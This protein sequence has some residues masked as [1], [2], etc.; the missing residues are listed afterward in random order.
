MYLHVMHCVVK[1]T[2][3]WCVA[4]LVYGLSQKHL[5]YF[6][7]YRMKFTR[8]CVALLLQEVGRRSLRNECLRFIAARKYSSS[9]SSLLA[10]EED[11]EAAKLRVNLTCDQY[12]LSA[13]ACLTDA[14]AA[15]TSLLAM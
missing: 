10:A 8:R 1:Q 6:N 15:L 2:L 14:E 4:A 9:P 3:A 11:K 5:K 12:F 13:G 7:A